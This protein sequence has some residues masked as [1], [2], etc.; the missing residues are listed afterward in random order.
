MG[1]IMKITNETNIYLLVRAKCV[2]RNLVVQAKQ[3]SLNTFLP[4]EV[5]RCGESNFGNKVFLLLVYLQNTL[6]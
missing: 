6:V 4:E 2:R 3:S 5:K 1:G